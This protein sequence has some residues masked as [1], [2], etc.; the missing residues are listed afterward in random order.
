MTAVPLSPLHEPIVLL[1]AS[2]EPLSMNVTLKRAARLL[3]KGKAIV[4]EAAKGRF[5]RH[6]PWPK[7]LI[8][9]KYVRVAHEVLYRQPAVSRK[10]VLKRDSHRCAYCGRQA[11]TIDH[12]LPKSRGGAMSW[13][14]LVAACPPC[15]G[16][17]KNRTP[18]EAGM[19][20]LFEPFVPSRMALSDPRLPQ[21]VTA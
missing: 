11:T 10:G 6:W 16:L 4:L 7:V 15:N 8:L 21:A 18:D 3:V 17:K 1:N 19:P 13:L 20:L 14:N 12:L 5:L 9:V 2:Y